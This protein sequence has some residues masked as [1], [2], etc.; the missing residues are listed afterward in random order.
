LKN[1]LFI[2]YYFPPIGG[3]GTQRSLKFIKFLPEYGWMPIVVT[4]FGETSDHY[5]PRDESFNCEIPK[6]VNV[7]R[8]KKIDN[9]KNPHSLY[10]RLL[11]LLCLP[12]EFSKSW[13]AEATRIGAKA[14][15][16]KTA[17][18]IYVSMSPFEGALAAS[19]LA[20]QFGLPWIADLRD[21]WALDEMQ[22]RVSNLHRRIERFKMQRS[23]LSA[24]AIIMNTPEA[25]KRL[26]SA[27]PL[28]KGKRIVT[29]TNGFD[30]DDFVIKKRKSS[31]QDIFTI[32]HA[33]HLHLESGISMRNKR[34][35]YKLFGRTDGG[36]DFLTRSHFY[37]LKA[38]EKWIICNQKERNSV[39]LSLIG[40]LTDNDRMLVRNSSVSDM[41]DLVGFQTHQETVNRML[42]ASLL[43]LPMHNLSSGIRATIVPGK[44]YE[45]MATG[46]PIMAALPQGDAMDFVRNS[47]VGSFCKPDA[48]DG[49]VH[50][51]DKQYSNWKL[52]KVSTNWNRDFVY[53]FE[54][55]KLT[56]LLSKEFDSSFR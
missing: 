4:G 15:Y 9:G 40:K 56:E 31:D 28:L 8:T 14:I 32:L 34:L 27:F 45:Y 20:T 50:I 3:S 2:A 47:G 30:A 5:S 26:I 22:V 37:I 12:S 29:I 41:V 33:G 43:F 46:K 7:Y 52:G 49:M 21:P 24:S 10:Q 55:R 54:R 1:V 42:Q 44:T 51:I 17:K 35:S 6:T 23:L 39:R 19:N 16:E 25:T 53:Q 48:V 13:A 36:V 11:D 18:L 38:L